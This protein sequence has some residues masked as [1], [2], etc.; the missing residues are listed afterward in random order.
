MEGF[1]TAFVGDPRVATVLL[2]IGAQVALA[3]LVAIRTATFEPGRLADYYRTRIIPYVGGTAIVWGLTRYLPEGGLGPYAPFV[4][5]GVF[6]LCW[7]T[8]IWTL[9]SDIWGSLRA[10][11]FGLPAGPEPPPSDIGTPAR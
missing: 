1:V 8:L 10:L 6:S 4:G 11:G 7:L 2:L 3:V 5:E 9:L